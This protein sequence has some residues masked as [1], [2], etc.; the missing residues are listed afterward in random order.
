MRTKSIILLLIALGFG[1]VASIGMSQLA[2]GDGAPEIPT[3][4][5]YVAIANVSQG[6]QLTEENV[7]LEQWPADRIPESAVSTPESIENMAARQPLFVGEPLMVDKLIDLDDSKGAAD[8]VKPGYRIVSVK[9]TME[10]SVSG[11]ILP[12]DHVDI[13]SVNRERGKAETILS[14]IEVFAIDSETKRMV[15][16]NGG[17]IQA[18]TVSVQV[19]PEQ[20]T[21]LTYHAGSGGSLRLALRSKED[22]DLE[23]DSGDSSIDPLLALRGNLPEQPVDDNSFVM[24][25]VNGDG[26]VQKYTWD[27]AESG[28]L[29]NEVNDG[30][31]PSF[32]G[33]GG[34]PPFQSGP[35]AGGEEGGGEEEGQESG[36][37]D[38]PRLDSVF[39]F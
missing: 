26:K 8:R 32:G 6:Q 25:V 13:M 21:K 20:A 4:P 34:L 24:Q 7:K 10:S 33:T 15:D 9:V 1:L 11:L 30:S 39:S 36:E 22:N 28:D 38:G 14:N 3:A 27:D 18:K 16:E 17:T 23:S 19:L 29:P 35:A 5:V 12:G 31:A 2:G 37:S